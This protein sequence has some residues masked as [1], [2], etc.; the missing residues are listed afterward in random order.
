MQRLWWKKRSRKTFAFLLVREK[1]AGSFFTSLVCP[2]KVQLS[3]SKALLLGRFLFLSLKVWDHNLKVV[4]TRPQK[5]SEPL[6]DASISASWIQSTVYLRWCCHLPENCSSPQRQ[7]FVYNPVIKRIL[8]ELIFLFDAL[9]FRSF[10]LSI[11]FHFLGRKI[12][13][14]GNNNTCGSHSTV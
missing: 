5:L 12:I 7:S 3:Y 14:A 9:N 11:L 2:L 10:E 1:T 6:T 4:F 13:F 8:T